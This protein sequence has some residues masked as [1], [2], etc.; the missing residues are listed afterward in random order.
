MTGKTS[1]GVAVRAEDVGKS[2][3]ALR[4][5]DSIKHECRLEIEWVSNMKQTRTR[6]ETNA[7]SRF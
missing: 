1:S 5:S 4:T 6:A 2:R 3:A 7:S